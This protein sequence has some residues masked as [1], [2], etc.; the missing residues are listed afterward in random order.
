MEVLSSGIVDDKTSNG[1]ER[2]F[3]DHYKAYYLV[4][5]DTHESI[6]EID[7]QNQH[8]NA[9]YHNNNTNYDTVAV[10]GDVFDVSTESY[11]DCIIEDH[12]LDDNLNNAPDDNISTE[13]VVVDA[14]DAYHTT[15]ND[16]SETLLSSP[17]HVIRNNAT[18]S[19]RMYSIYVVINAIFILIFFGFI[20]ID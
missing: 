5:R 13:E 8:S 11:N 12:L 20:T 14:S 17:H 9:S 7:Y 6:W 16:D 19:Y 4:H 2:Y 18:D 10:S 3:D 15:T 1:W